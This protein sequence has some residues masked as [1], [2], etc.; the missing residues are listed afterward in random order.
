MFEH[1]RLL[2]ADPILGLMSL[3]RADTNPLKVDLGVGVYKNEQ[4]QTPVLEAV[5][6]AEQRLIAAQNSKVYVG[7]AGNPDFNSGMSRLLLGDSPLLRDQRMAAVQTPGGCGA[8]RVAAELIKVA[9][10]GATIWVSDPTWGNHIPLLGNAGIQIRTYPYYDNAAAT[11]RFDAM[12]EQLLAVPA[13]DLVLL[14]GCCHNPTGADLSHEQWEVVA[15]IASQRGFIPFIDVAY[16]GFADGLEEDVYGLR[17]LA[18][19]VPEVVVAVSCSKN[20]GLY[21]ERVG[22]LGV[23]TPSS[24]TS[25]AV[26]SH[27]L[28]IVRGIYSMPPDHGA[29]IV[30]NILGDVEL[31]A[32]WKSELE[33][34]RNRISDLRQ[35]FC[36]EMRARLHSERFDFVAHQKGMFSY[37]GLSEEEVLQLRERDAIYLLGSSRASIAGLGY[38]NIQ[39]VCDAVAR[40]CLT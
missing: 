4:G 37:L 22:F 3:F 14:H 7:P 24:M 13:G 11:I 2:P 5:K 15:Q 18:S 34:M 25:S 16:Q 9:Y 1:L 39:Y 10:P 36:S 28:S 8:L 6:R 29:S 30:A 38:N 31:T 20:F 23:I 33:A 26:Q 17:L 27:L 21:R 12:V 19:L 35:A 40:L 32:L